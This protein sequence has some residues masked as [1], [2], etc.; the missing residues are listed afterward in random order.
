MKSIGPIAA[1]LLLSACTAQLTSCFAATGP[2]F[3]GHIKAVI[4]RG[5]QTD[6][7]LYTVG[8]NCLRVEMAATN[9]PEPVDIL[10]LNSGC[11]TL[12]FPNNRSFVRIKA[13]AQNST[14]M[15]PPGIPRISGMASLPA[16]PQ[17]PPPMME[18][19]EL[20]ATDEKTNLLGFVCERYEINQRGET[21]VIWATDQ[22]FPFQNYLRNPT[23]RFG[24][25]MIE[26]QWA[27][28]LADKKL[29]PLL[30]IL[31]SSTGAERLRFKVQSVTPGRITDETRFQPPPD[32]QEVQP[33]RF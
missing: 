5:G 19:L 26:E 30:A 11:L 17:R 23:P 31:K 12:L 10:E 29:F 7:W 27:G 16:A 9:W 25:R 24:P 32:Y 4:T 8:A 2:A 6:E 3:E 28:L 14:T 20:N 1:I 21:M 18:K 22:L 33:L 15:T 13:D